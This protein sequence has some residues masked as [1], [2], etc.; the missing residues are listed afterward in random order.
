MGLPAGFVFERIEDAECGRAEAEREPERGRRF[1][2]RELKALL[3]EG[4]YFV[5]L[6]RLCFEPDE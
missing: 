4:G 2:I 3:Q 5:L 6:A 1:L